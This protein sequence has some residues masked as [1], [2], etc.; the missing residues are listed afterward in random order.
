[1][2]AGLPIAYECVTHAG[3]D[4]GQVARPKRDDAV[5]PAIAG[6]RRTVR[7]RPALPESRT[8]RVDSMCDETKRKEATGVSSR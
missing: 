2:G 8:K 5:P 3:R 7:E 6:T 4:A 1:M